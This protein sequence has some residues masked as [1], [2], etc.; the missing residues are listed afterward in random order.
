VN[1]ISEMLLSKDSRF[2]REL[3]HVGFLSK[4]S[5]NK[6]SASEVYTGTP[7]SK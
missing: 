1:A 3:A 5:S 4:S 7:L 6:Q 2:G